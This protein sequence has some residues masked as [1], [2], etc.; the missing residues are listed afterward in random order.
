MKWRADSQ[1]LKP[2]KFE[3]KRDP[4][5]GFYLYVFEG[6]RCVR[7]HLQDML[8]IAIESAFEEYGVPKDVW[9]KVEE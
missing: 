2:R 7:D 6:D 5:V 4:H 1:S 3:I 8:E 9:R